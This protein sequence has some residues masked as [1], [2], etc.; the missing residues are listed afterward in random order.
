MEET[1][2]GEVSGCSRLL[3][4]TTQRILLQSIVNMW[5]LRLSKMRCL[6]RDVKGPRGH[7][8]VQNL[9]QDA[10]AKRGDITEVGNGTEGLRVHRSHPTFPSSLAG[11]F[12]SHWHDTSQ[13]R[14]V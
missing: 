6:F 4:C 14:V 5:K 8:K 12:Q 10:D 11:P 2:H 1:P 7:G 13:L 9:E 3:V